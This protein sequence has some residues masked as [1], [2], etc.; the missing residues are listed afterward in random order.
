MGYV[1]KLE[2]GGAR[3]VML[4]EGVTGDNAGGAKFVAHATRF[5][6]HMS[7]PMGDLQS[8][9]PDN[10]MECDVRRLSG[11]SPEERD[12]AEGLEGLF[13]ST[14]DVDSFVEKLSVAL[15]GRSRWGRT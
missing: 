12:S 14:E 5:A 7:V 1:R 3:T 6:R 13:H 2:D 15:E 11:S 10:T 4:V 9:L 8:W